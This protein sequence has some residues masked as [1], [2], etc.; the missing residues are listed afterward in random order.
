MLT[1]ATQGVDSLDQTRLDALLAP[2]GDEI[3]RFPFD[4]TRKLASALRLLRTIRRKRPSL[5][6]MEGTGIAGG[7]VMLASHALFRT[8][9]VVATGD[10]VGPYLA[11]QRR[12]PAV[13]GWA[14]EVLLLRLSAAVIGWTPYIVGRALTFGAPRAVT[15]PGW[16]RAEAR[17]GARRRTRADLGISDETIVFGIAGSLRWSS[18]NGYAY[19]AELIR[20]LREIGRRDLAVVI[21]GDGSGKARLQEMAGA[22]LDARVKFVGRV[23]AQAVPDYLAAFDVASLPQSRD[24]VGV[25]R[26]STKLPEYL[27]AHLPIVT[28]RLPVAY[29]VAAKWSWRLPG[30]APWAPE[31]VHALTD[32]M[33]TVTWPAIEARRPPAG[34]PAEGLFSMPCQQQ[35]VVSLLREIL[36]DEQ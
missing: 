31:Y 16:S 22:D 12:V 7:I 21:V 34:D 28:A 2:L 5:V 29:D 6:I 4:R 35:R 17:D 26:Y 14:Y 15:A 13:V 27:A 11:A 25:F 18:R 19:G 24:Q 20:A 8:R 33:A 30:Q 1:F 36:A 32:L 23:P 9:Y 10:A 3:F